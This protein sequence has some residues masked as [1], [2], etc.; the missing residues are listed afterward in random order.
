MS[1]T[2]IGANLSAM[3]S[4]DRLFHTNREIRR[5][6]IRLAS[7]KRIN[8]VDED[9]AGF[10]LA[11]GLESRGRSLLQAADNVATARNVLAI[12]EGAYRAI[13]DILLNIVEKVVQGADD[14]Y[15]VDQRAA[16]QGQIDALVDEIDAIVEET[17]F[18]GTQLID[19]S[20]VSKVFQTGPDAGDVLRVDLENAHSSAFIGFRNGFDVIAGVNDR[21]VFVEDG[22]T[23]TATLTPG[24]YTLTG[25]ATELESALDA[26]S[27]RPGVNYGVSFDDVT[28]KYTIS[29]T[30]G[31]P[32]PI[33]LKWTDSASA[34]LAGLFGF[35]T[36]QDDNVNGPG[37][38]TRV[39]V[40]DYVKSTVTLS[41]ANAT[42]AADTL[43]TVHNALNRI[44]GIAQSV[45]EYTVRLDLKN[46]VLQTTIANTEAT[47]SRVEDADYAKE[48]M[49]LIQLQILQQAG[50][51]ALSQANAA[52]QAVL[53]LI[54]Q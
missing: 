48:M 29:K 20:F 7:G 46:E 13:S 42:V 34:G 22:V 30:G 15:N 27:V 24:S 52:P 51:S 6:L 8:R 11:R 41:V 35:S 38:P 14:A 39:A 9:P 19:G 16:I 28:G 45:G 12:A 49:G 4:M 53:G 1:M 10:S 37:N 21:L 33:L 2:R 31:P 54:V 40:S 5:R 36:S 17:S 44:N 32:V 3:R 23:L 18:N 43:D 47:R 25:L 26:A 50:F